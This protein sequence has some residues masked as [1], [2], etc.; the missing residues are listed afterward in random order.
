MLD[1][2]HADLS[3]LA[4]DSLTSLQFVT[5]CAINTVRPMTDQTQSPTRYLYLRRMT[6]QSFNERTL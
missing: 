5:K 2:C 3:V 4:K 1:V 6:G